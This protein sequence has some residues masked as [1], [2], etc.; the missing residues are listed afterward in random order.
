MLTTS[1]PAP[2]SLIASAPTWSPETSL[3]RY[4]CFCASFP[5]RWIW[6]M[7]RFECAPYESAT[8][9]DARESSSIDDDVGEVA[10]VRPAVLLGHGHAVGSEIA[11]LLPEILGKQI[12]PIDLGRARRDFLVGEASDRRAERIDGLAELES[13]LT[14]LRHGYLRR[15]RRQAARWAG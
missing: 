15:R 10:E 12:V 6:L 11:E 8:D 14:E 4:F 3:G 5:L 1:E 13:E 2:G 9:A 7:Q